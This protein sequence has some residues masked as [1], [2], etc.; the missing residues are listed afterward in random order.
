MEPRVYLNLNKKRVF[1]KIS[2]T[3][4]TERTRTVYRDDRHQS[5][6]FF[7]TTAACFAQAVVTNRIHVQQ[8]QDNCR[9]RF[10][11]ILQLVI[12]RIKMDTSKKLEAVLLL[13]LFLLIQFLKQ[14]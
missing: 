10:V 13:F 9:T 6:R 11:L 3:K 12:Y 14:F 7:S 8:I 4:R 2:F 1:C 5:Q